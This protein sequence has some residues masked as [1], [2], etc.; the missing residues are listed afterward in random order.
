[1]TKLA[2]TLEAKPCAPNVTRA[3]TGAGE[4]SVDRFEPKLAECCVERS[5]QVRG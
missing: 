2:A 1:M 4:I 5:F 3:N